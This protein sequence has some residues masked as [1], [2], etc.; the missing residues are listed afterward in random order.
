MEQ[1]PKMKENGVIMILS[2]LDYITP[3]R[4]SLCISAGKRES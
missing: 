4:L 1:N 3:I 2:S